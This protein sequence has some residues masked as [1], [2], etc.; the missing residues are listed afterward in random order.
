MSRGTT[1]LCDIGRN[2]GDLREDV[3]DIVQPLRQESPTRLGEVEAGDGAE[4]DAK[5]LE[6]DGEQVGQEDDEEQAETVGCAGRNIGGVVS[7]ID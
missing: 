6:E 2:D 5:T 4:F 1:D 7:G 3:E